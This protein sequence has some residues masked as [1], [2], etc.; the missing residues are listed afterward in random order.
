MTMP[1]SAVAQLN[2]D[3]VREATRGRWRDTIYPSLGIAVGNGKH[4]ACPA[5]G[6]KDRFRCDDLN[7]SGSWYCNQCD[8]QAGDG[9]ALIQKVRNC[10]FPHSLQLV[11]GILG[12]DP[13]TP[14]DRA[15]LHRE[16]IKRERERCKKARQQERKG[17]CIDACREAEATIATASGID[18]SRWSDQ[19]LDDALGVLADAYR[20]L[21]REGATDE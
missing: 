1:P 19:Q 5:C 7:G 17:L 14:I 15:A 13:S 16:R 18:I 12:L 3:V 6:G 4:C 2:A 11:A 10:S 8:P 9:F 20:V 21:E